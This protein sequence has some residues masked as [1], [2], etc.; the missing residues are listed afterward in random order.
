MKSDNKKALYESIMTSVAREVKKTLNESNL[1]KPVLINK[2]KEMSE[3]L[4]QNGIKYVDF[5]GELLVGPN[6]CV[7]RYDEEPLKEPLHISYLNTYWPS[8]E[9]VEEDE[10]G[11]NYTS[12]DLT[13]YKENIL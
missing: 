4:Y 8:I 12:D 13:V 11:Y 7:L 2:I 9:Y 6:D 1:D 5:N 10:M 3:K